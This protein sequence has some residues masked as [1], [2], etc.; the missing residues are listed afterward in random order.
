MTTVSLGRAQKLCPVALR[1]SLLRLAME[2]GSWAGLPRVIPEPGIA[3]KSA[4][5]MEDLR[6]RAASQG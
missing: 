5:A 2:E 3:V 1:M 4:C 6:G